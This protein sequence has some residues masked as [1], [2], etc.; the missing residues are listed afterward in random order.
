MKLGIS[1]NLF[2]NFPLFEALKTV[3]SIGYEGVELLTDIPHF[4]P[5]SATLKNVYEILELLG[6]LNLGIS[7]INAFMFFALGNSHFPSYLDNSSFRIEFT[8]WSIF[9][10]SI[11]GSK[12][13]SI[14]PGGKQQTNFETDLEKF[15]N[16]L[17]ELT[18][19]AQ[20]FN[21]K[22]LVEP[23]PQL[24][25]ENVEQCL[26]LVELLKAKSLP[27]SYF[28]I[29]ADLGHFYCV[30]ES[31][32]NV[33]TQLKEYIGHVHIEDISRDRKHFHLVP[34]D[35][36]IDFAEIVYWLKRINYNGW[37]TVELYPFQDEPIDAAQR[38][39]EHLKKIGF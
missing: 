27:D 7:N 35:G 17:K 16:I 20:K 37:V 30:G 22:I 38:A 33:F 13:V 5:P 10:A 12:T 8:K 1:T 11:L 19:I 25:I 21:V 4:Y 2:K 6:Q 31:F 26:R 15:S 32:E 39:F 3:R 36:V 28:G 29:N 14:E 9:T 34:G 23:E 18:S 24:L